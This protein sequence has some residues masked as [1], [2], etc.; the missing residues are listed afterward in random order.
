MTATAVQILIADSAGNPKDWVTLDYASH[1]L[2]SDKVVWQ[3][4]SVVKTYRGGF[5][6]VTGLRS[7][8]D[9]HSILGISGKLLGDKFFTRTTVYTDREILYARDRYLCAYC[10]DEFSA[11]KLTIDHVHPQ[12]RG[13]KNVWQ[14]CVTAC[15]TCNH[16]KGDK[17]PEEAKMPLLYV[18]YAPNMFEKMIL[19]NRNILSDQMDF[20]KARVPKTSRVFL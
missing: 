17:T 11:Y 14:N 4:G 15:K 7:T 1:Y 16:K 8:L 20:L 19:K 10:G 2:A 12:S 9:I 18:P 3:A 5:N 13:G 6:H